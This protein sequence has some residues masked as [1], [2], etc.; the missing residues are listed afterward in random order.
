M[1]LEDKK[2]IDAGILGCDE[3]TLNEATDNLEEAFETWKGEAWIR[4]ERRENVN[5]MG[6]E[7]LLDYGHF[8]NSR[9]LQAIEEH[10]TPTAMRCVNLMRELIAAA[11]NKGFFSIVHDLTYLSDNRREEID[12]SRNSTTQAPRRAL[13]NPTKYIQL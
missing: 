5:R 11:R 6:Y 4:G 9:C 2:Y 12:N 8:L 10:K 3:E 1:D 13:F 7:S